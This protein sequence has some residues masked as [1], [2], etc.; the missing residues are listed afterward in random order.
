MPWQTKTEALAIASKATGRGR[1]SV[2]HI[3]CLLIAGASLSS[4]GNDNS[5]NS[6]TDLNLDTV[7]MVFSQAPIPNKKLT[8]LSRPDTT[9]FPGDTLLVELSTPE[10]VLPA[11]KQRTTFELTPDKYCSVKK[12]GTNSYY[13]YVSSSAKD[14]VIVHTGV[15]RPNTVFRYAFKD[16]Y[17]KVVDYFYERDLSDVGRHAWRIDSTASAKN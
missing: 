6:A 9:V 14:Y 7:T 15:R 11:F 10:K 4:C 5:N 1:T 17:G 3:L 2:K 16:D 12:K 13:V 8:N